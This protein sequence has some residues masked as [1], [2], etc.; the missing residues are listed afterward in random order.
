MQPKGPEH[1]SWLR[2]RVDELAELERRIEGQRLPHVVRLK[3][4]VLLL[5]V[6]AIGAAVA[7]S[8]DPTDR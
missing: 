3:L 2:G 6:V 5:L 7:V 8:F 1:E 4:T